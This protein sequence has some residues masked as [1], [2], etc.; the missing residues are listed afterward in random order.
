MRIKSDFYLTVDKSKVFKTLKCDQDSPIYEETVSAYEKLLSGLNG[1]VKPKG[2]YTFFDKTGPFNSIDAISHCDVLLLAS[3]TLGDEIA[4]KIQK[5]FDEGEYLEGMLLD[6]ISDELLFNL[7]RQ[8]YRDIF[9]VCENMAVGLSCRLSPGDKYLPIE[10]QK[11]IYDALDAKKVLEMDI[12]E[13]AM[14]KPVKS[15]MYFYGVHKTYKLKAHDTG[16]DSC[17]NETCMFREQQPVIVTVQTS[18]GTKEI[19][20]DGQNDLLHALVDSYSIPSPCSGNGNC[21]KCIIKVTEGMLE[22]TKTDFLKLSQDQLDDGYRLACQAYPKENCSI[23]IEDFSELNAEIISDFILRD[24]VVNPWVELITV[25]FPV[26]KGKKNMDATQLINDQVGHDYIFTLNALRNLSEMYLSRKKPSE[27]YLVARDNEILDI[28]KEKIEL[29]GVAIDVGTTTVV[30]CLVNLETGIV[31]DNFSVLNNQKQYGADV[32]S[33][34]MYASE[35]TDHLMKL[36]KSIQS[37]IMKG[38]LRLCDENNIIHAQ[39]SDVVVSGNTTMLHLLMGLHCKSIGEAPFTSLTT[40]RQIFDFNEVFSD[41]QFNTKI[42][43]LPGIASYVG[44]DLVMGILHSR[45]YEEQEIS[46]LI[47]IGTNGE[48]VIGNKDKLF[49]LA[50]AAGPAFEGANISCGIG[51][52]QGAINSV[53]IKDKKVDYGTIGNLEPIGICGS[54]VVDI[55]MGLIENEFIDESGRLNDDLFDSG[56]FVAKSKNQFSIVFNQKDIREVQLAKSAIR[57]GIEV[58]IERFGCTIDDVKN[59]YLAGGFG[60]KMDIASA[61]GIGMI[62]KVLEDRVVSIGNSAL[63]G[64]LDYMLNKDKEKSV[65]DIIQLCQYIELSADQGFNALFVENLTF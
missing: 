30:L 10:L 62:P 8:L 23:Y 36:S 32:I 43:M 13:S 52:I 44:S 53:K 33:R 49:C 31:V 56:F 38:L 5:L 48:M 3:L 47:D 34:I 18:I 35:S 24:R 26:G 19:A 4:I 1:Y 55:V 29:Y 21:G 60:N 50:T 37:D 2:I 28:M 9:E 64:A 11:T 61:V 45:L 63:G 54:G 40:A 25:D 51:S 57:S 20:F 14:L 6:I 41:H 15:L 65:Y 39:I 12:T 58:L 42:T 16:C 59:V 7:S 22:I 27:I 46:I 17:E